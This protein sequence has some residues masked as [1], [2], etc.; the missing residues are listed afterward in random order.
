MV[1]V[2]VNGRD[3]FFC[4]LRG[5]RWR[6]ELLRERLLK[7]RADAICLAPR[8]AGAT[9]PQN[10]RPHEDGNDLAVAR[11]LHLFSALDQVELGRQGLTGFA[12]AYDGHTA[13][14]RSCT[15]TYKG[16][17]ARRWGRL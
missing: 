1:S 12:G 11:D 9:R 7:K 17:D 16:R 6:F 13:I 8:V 15:L 14:V 2:R 5:H 4:S 10:V 3:K